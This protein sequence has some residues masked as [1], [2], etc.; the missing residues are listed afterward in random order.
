MRRVA[1]LALVVAAAAAGIGIAQREQGSG[2][3]RLTV[4]GAAS[5]ARVLPRLDPSPRYQFAGSNTLALQIE[6]GANADVFLSASPRYVRELR[7]RKLTAGRPVWFAT[8]RLVLIVPRSNPAG[9]RSPRDLARPGVRL[10]LAAPGVPAGDYARQALARMRLQRALR[11]VVSS[12]ADVEGVVSKV[13]LG[14]ADAGFAY[15]TDVRAVRGQV[16]AVPLP[17]A[18]RTVS[19]YGG[20]VVEGTRDALHARG[21]LMLLL[22]PPGQKLLHAA[23]FGAPPR[24]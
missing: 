2:A 4:F 16:R 19:V 24:R 12:E 5:L 15:A 3:D 20:V 18:G 11:N 1:I 17:P 6:H 13:A 23:G 14:E 21:F 22:S 10:V 7:A 9:I 8:N